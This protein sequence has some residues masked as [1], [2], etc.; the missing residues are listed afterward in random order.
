MRAEQHKKTESKQRE[1]G[2]KEYNNGWETKI[3]GFEITANKWK[4]KGSPDKEV[5]IHS[6]TELQAY[7]SGSGVFNK[8]LSVPYITNAWCLANSISI[9]HIDTLI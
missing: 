4:I 7:L 8:H 5:Q 6:N 1:D 9:Q 3:R 2:A